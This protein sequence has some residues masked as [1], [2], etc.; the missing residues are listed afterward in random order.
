[1]ET[2]V[3][4][5]ELIKIPSPFF[6]EEVIAIY[7]EKYLKNLGFKTSR[8]PVK[9]TAVINH[10][11]I[12]LNHYNVLGEKGNGEKSFLLYAHMDTVPPVKEW[13]ETNLNPYKPIFK[14]NKIYGLGASDM[15][16]GITA[17]IKA[18]EDLNPKNYKIKVCFG[19][20]EE[21]ESLGA[22]TLVNSNFISDCA[23]CIVPEVGSGLA[24]PAIENLI[25]GRHG[26][27]RVGIK[28][29]GHAAHAAT[30]EFIIN[31]I[32]HALKFIEQTKK[33]DLGNDPD[34]QKGNVSIGG[35]HAE[36]RGL[37]S[38]EEC[39]IWF[40]NLYCPPI[41]SCDIFKQYEKIC[42]NL[43]KKSPVSFSIINLLKLDNED[44][45][46]F[47]ERTTPFMEPW[48]IKKD[49]PLVKIASMAIKNIT[50]KSAV[51]TCGNSNAD[52]N[53]ISLFMPTIVIPPIGGNEHQAGEY[54]LLN[55]ILITEKIIK[56]TITNYMEKITKE[57]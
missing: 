55:S 56:M 24:I 11:K 51:L 20:D 52:E 25:I 53:Y 22:Y 26:R 28:I 9:R 45:Q 37:S 19:V 33:I 27:N 48:K 6:Y 32:E 47:T 5:E 36:C 23:G 38:P 31:P 57:V 29:K 14:E 44:K 54:I 3:L 1:M 34:M 35:I 15:K 40:D 46:V 2:K 43:N 7:L 4:L 13:I 10:K 12:K 16:A 42:K 39:I 17:I 8:Q 41:N 50:G 18:L 49:N 21:N 30:P